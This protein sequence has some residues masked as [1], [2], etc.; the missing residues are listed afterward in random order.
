M[1]RRNLFEVDVDGLRQLVAKR[2][3]SFILFELYQ[4]ARDQNV[5]KIGVTFE[6]VGKTQYRLFIEDD[7]PNGFADLSHAYTLF[8]PSVKKDRPDTAGLFNL[9]EK[10]VI[11]CCT[12]ATILT[13]TGGVRFDAEGRHRVRQKRQVGSS[14]EGHI[15]ITLD[16]FE[17]AS[18]DFGL[19]MPKPGVTVTFNGEV[20]PH[21]DPL[22][23]FSMRLPTPLAL[24]ISDDVKTV[25]RETKVDIF[26]P[27]EG[28]T[29][30][31]YEHGIPVVENASRW[32]CVSQ[33]VPVP[34]DRDNVPPSYL[35]KLHVACVNEMHEALRPEDT[36]L[37]FVAEAVADKNIAPQA[38]QTWKNGKYGPKAVIFD[39]SDPE[40]NKR[41]VAEGYVV[42][43]GAQESPE[44]FA[45][46]R[47]DGLVQ[48][49]GR[50]TPSDKP[51]GDGPPL[52]LLDERKKTHAM[53]RVGEYALLIFRQVVCPEGSL[54]VVWANE[55]KW[56]YGATFGKAVGG[57]RLIFNVGRL[58]YDWFERHPAESW[59]IEA[60]LI[61][62]FGHY[63]C[64]DHLS[65]DYYDA[66]CRIGAKLSVLKLQQ[67]A[68]FA[69]F[70]GAAQ[71]ALVAA[72]AAD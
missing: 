44:V 64:G 60:L 5:S 37:N 46:I 70:R 40:S 30:M 15:N 42:I 54:E 62:E 57:G 26:A 36:T 33:K 59:E 14:F 53:R 27:L 3:K 48:P 61:H 63:D 55:P 43:H 29:P 72:D 19:V 45:N 10:L 7:D 31:L 38:L 68:L 65:A 47:R 2:G 52:K 13:T 6:R 49:A 21:R 24:S 8:A 35:R 39:P 12:E 50:V 22:K 66:L 9:G 20:I 28:E 23:T 1:G 51:F 41:A 18:R 25:I 58:G 69:G 32:H 17:Q 34:L 67:P 16:E 11:A 56:P 4:N 71:D